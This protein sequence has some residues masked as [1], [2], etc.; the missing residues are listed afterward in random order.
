MPGYSFQRVAFRPTQ[1]SGPAEILG[2][3]ALIGLGANLENP[4]EMIASAVARL[5][6]GLGLELL[7][8]SSLYLSEPQGGP[9]GQDWYHNAVAAF[10][11]ALAPRE[12]LARLLAVEETLGRRRAEKN[13]P[14]NIDL[15]WLAQGGLVVD[16]PPELIIPHP[17]LA[18]RRFVLAPLAEVAPEWRHPRLGL[19]ARELLAALPAAGQG[20]KKLPGAWPWTDQGM[21]LDQYSAG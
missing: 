13:G 18:E 14:R 8:V 2:S 21:A 11:S 12:L 1:P 5:A 3:P 16:E 7:A 6:A 15:D 19:S 9:A 17:R 4:A 20:L 10:A